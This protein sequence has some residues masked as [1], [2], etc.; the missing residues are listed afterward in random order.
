MDHAHALAWLDAWY[1]TPDTSPP[2]FWEDLEALMAQ[3]PLTFRDPTHV[4]SRET[5]GMAPEYDFSH[6][7]R[8]P[9]QGEP[10]A[11]DALSSYPVEYDENGCAWLLEH[12][13]KI[14]LPLSHGTPLRIA[15]ISPP[16]YQDQAP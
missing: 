5:C 11:Q 10:A 2:G 1:A 12:A 16:P 4:C 3:Y 15:Q 7:T 14:R 9:G 8:G 6:G 13:T